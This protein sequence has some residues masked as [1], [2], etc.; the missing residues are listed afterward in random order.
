MSPATKRIGC[1]NLKTLIET[2]KLQICDFDTYSEL[3]TFVADKTSFAAE[4]GAND[5]VVMTLVLFAWAATQKYFREIVNHDLRQQLQ[6]QTMNQVD[7][8]VL[9]A[10]IIEDGRENPFILEGGDVWEM[11]SGGDT[12]AGYFRSL[13]K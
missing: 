11:A 8:E 6:L 5:D 7:E 3:T 2:D 4:E 13:H 12:Y 1:S 9:P 10:P